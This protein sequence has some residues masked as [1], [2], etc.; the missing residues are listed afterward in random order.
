MEFLHSAGLLTRPAPPCTSATCYARG[1][2]R[3]LGPMTYVI[4][5]NCCKDA[6]C[7]TACPVNCIAPAPGTDGSIRSPML[8]ID[9]AVCIDC[10]RAPTCARSTPPSRRTSLAEA[11][12][13]YADLNADYY[14]TAAE[15]G[16]GRRRRDRCS[17][18]GTA[19][20]RLVAAQRLHR[21]RRRR[22]RNRSGRALR[23]RNCSCSTRPSRV[24]LIDR[25]PMAGGLVRYGVAPDHPG[26]K[27]I[28]ETLGRLY[29]HPRVRLLL[30][31]DVGA[32]VTVDQLSQNFDA[33]VYAVGAATGRRLEV[34]GEDLPGL[35]TGPEFVGWYNAHPD[36][37]ARRRARRPTSGRSSSA[38]GTSRSTSPAS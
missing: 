23:G 22:R 18:R 3:A 38:P 27:R 31:V 34:P 21:P 37:P 2:A 15:D 20:L 5:Q 36:V 6:T 16:G 28:G 35:H 9:P 11:G 29:N 17:T 13:V 32:D 19:E 1:A 10:G 4:T 8:Y 12:R 30:G 26:T 24:T 7:V 14:R 33:V 25:L